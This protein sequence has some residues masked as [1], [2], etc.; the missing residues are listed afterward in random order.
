MPLLDPLYLEEN[1]SNTVITAVHR[2]CAEYGCAITTDNGNE[3]V[4]VAVRLV[5]SGLREDLLAAL[6]REMSSSAQPRLVDT[7]LV[8]EDE[9]FIL[10]DM[11][12]VLRNAGFSVKALASRAEVMKWLTFSTPSAAV[13]DFELKDGASTDVASLLQLR[14][15]PVIFCS[16]EDRNALPSGLRQTSWVRKPFL[17]RHLVEIVRRARGLED[18][19]GDPE[20][21]PCTADRRMTPNE[22]YGKE[23]DDARKSV[24]R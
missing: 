3:A 20:A 12:D 11:E 5:K 22:K 18:H 9:P 2:W 19:C 15:A 14:G 4:A 7:I 17:D 10:I 24:H 1:Q 16:A 8:L 13:L 21:T 6:T 23:K